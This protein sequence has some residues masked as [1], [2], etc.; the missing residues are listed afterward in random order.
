MGAA[1][2]STAGSTAGSGPASAEQVER[3]F[4]EL[5]LKHHV[6]G[7]QLS[8]YRDGTLTRCA[9]GVSSVRTNTPVTVDTAF[10]YGSVTKFFTAELVMQFVSDGDLDL[11]EPLSGLLPDLKRATNPELGTA[12]VRQLLS[13]TAGLADSIEYPDMRGPSYRR[14]AAVCGETPNLFPPGLAFSYSNTGYCLLGSVVEAVSGMDWWTAVDSCLLRPLSIEPAFLHDPRPRTDRPAGSRARV[15]AEGHAVRAGDEHAEPVDHMTALSLAAAGGLAGS[16]TDLVTAARL[17]LDDRN[18]FPQRELLPEEAVH[19]MRESVPD[20]E[21]FGLAD[22]WGLGLMC[23]R[24]GEE[25]WFGHD[26]AVGGAT[27][28]LRIHPGRN[29][30]LAVTTNSTAGPK[31]WEDLVGRL[32]AAGL[33]LGHYSL[34]A[35]D[36]PETAD[37]GD[38][39]GTYANGDLH[40]MVVTDAEGDLY[41]TREDYSDYRLT[42]HADDLF[43][44]QDREH[45]ALPIVGRFVRKH[46]GG[47]VALLQYGGRALQRL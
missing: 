6:T 15:L 28:N 22:A 44:A 45:D 19:Q 29:L 5:V 4:E 17:H 11:D 32:R 37:L 25:A 47:P 21:P 43:V 20:A 30:A 33:D 18:T 7:A 16:A 24:S 31:L 26:G 1:V 36:A 39:L 41:L 13:H 3:I 8:L 46:P 42:I 9:A 38:H 12:T 34:P 27:C 2:G 40:L 35:P 10:P 23:H 14:F